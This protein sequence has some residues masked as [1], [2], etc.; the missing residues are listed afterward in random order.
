MRLT[1]KLVSLVATVILVSFFTFLLTQLIPG[2]PVISVLGSAYNPQTEEGREQIELVREELGLNDPFPVRYFN[3]ATGVFTGDLGNKIGVNSAGITTNRILKER[4]PVTLEIM[5]L[6]QIFALLVAIPAGIL[7]AH[8]EDRFADKSVTGFSFAM[9]ALPSFVIALILVFVF[10]VKLGWLPS[11][12][13]TRLTEDLSENLK[14]MIIPV[15]SLGPG[16]AAVYTRLLRAEM[17]S[18]LKEDYILMAKAK[19]ISSRRVLFRHA[20]RPSS[21]ALLTIAGINIGAL[22]GGAVIIEQFMAIPGVG[23]ALVQAV[24][25]REYEVILSLV[26][27]ISMFYVVAN[28]L[29]DLLYSFLDPRIRRGTSR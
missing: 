14:S 1:T 17:I 11:S 13:Y 2:D 3:W 25:E 4:L 29:V 12:G 20:L 28:F 27:V 16:L 19:G 18:T 6:T 15:L 22:I 23:G 21:F 9:L 8:K 24:A 5:L 26:F 7:S 10:A